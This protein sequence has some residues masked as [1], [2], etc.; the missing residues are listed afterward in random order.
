MKTKDLMK[1]ENFKK[2]YEILGVKRAWKNGH[3]KLKVWYLHV[4]IAKKLL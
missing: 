3:L 1:L 2:I 4:K